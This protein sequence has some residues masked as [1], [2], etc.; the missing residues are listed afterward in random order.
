[1]WSYIVLTS[2]SQVSARFYLKDIAWE[3]MLKSPKPTVL[4]NEKQRVKVGLSDS[5]NM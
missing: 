4:F 3:P 2:Q 1:M 5:M